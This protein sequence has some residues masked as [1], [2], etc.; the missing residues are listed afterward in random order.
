MIKIEQNVQIFVPGQEDLYRR[1]TVRE[2]ARVQSF[3]DDF[4]FLYDD[5]NYG[6]KMIGNAVPVELAYHV[7]TAVKAALKKHNA[8]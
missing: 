7:A 3:P 5:V 4:V 8:I 2:V 6:Y 1:M